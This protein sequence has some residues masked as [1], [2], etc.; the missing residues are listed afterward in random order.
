MQIRR[1]LAAL[2]TTALAWGGLVIADLPTAKAVCPAP[3]SGDPTVHAFVDLT[4]QGLGTSAPVGSLTGGHLS[5]PCATSCTDSWTNTASTAEDTETYTVSADSGWAVDHWSGCS[6]GGGTTSTCAVTPAYSVSSTQTADNTVD[7]AVYFRD[8]TPPTAQITSGPPTYTNQAATFTFTSDGTGTEATDTC[9]VDGGSYAPCSSPYAVGLLADGPHTLT[10]RATDGGDNTA[11]AS[12]SFT[13]DTQAPT[14]T[15]S[16][17]PAQG[18]YLNSTSASFTFSAADPNILQADCGDVASDAAHTTVTRDAC[19]SFTAPPNPT[20][21]GW[22]E[23][24]TNLPQGLHTWT[25]R[26][27][28]KAGNTA[29]QWRS[30]YVDSIAPTATFTGGPAEGATTSNTAPTFDFA[31]DGTGSTATA[32]CRLD[33]PVSIAPQPCTGSNSETLAG[34]TDGSYLLTLHLVDQAGNTADVARSFRVDTSVPTLSIDSGPA[35]G[36]YLGSTNATFGF[37]AGSGATAIT[38]QVDQDAARP[39][40]SNSTDLLTNLSDGSHSWTVQA[41]N[42]AGTS[43]TQTRTFTV[44]TVSPTAAITSGVADLGFTV[45]PTPTFDFVLDGTGSVPT[46]KCSVDSAQATT[47]TTATSYVTPA[48]GAGRH[49]VHVAVTDAAGNTTT[50]SRAFT[51]DLTRP[52]VGPRRHGRC[53]Q[54]Q[55]LSRSRGTPSIRAA[56]SRRAT[57]KCNTPV[58]QVGSAPGRRRPAGSGRRRR[59]FSVP[60]PRRHLLR[61]CPRPRH[62]R[63][64]EQLVGTPLHSASDRRC[65][66]RPIVTLEEDRW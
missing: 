59:A 46:A 63:Q 6:S 1:L 40:A 28:D 29:Q 66:A 24:L 2:I 57:C 16:S 11:Q 58:R 30:W 54:P 36:S 25:V 41:T 19:G 3:C 47:C 17:G 15:I 34:L 51:I 55:P 39:C 14:T 56:A 12:R 22:Q 26:A 32:T 5:T 35:A 64:H 61:P 8:T 49:T 23:T 62:R 21:V 52:T 31:L 43:T 48:L 10:V 4:V 7:V 38:C 9:A 42:A 20:P 60:E 18:S 44:D 33:G 53:S 65:V 50:I 37:T 13:V 45:D 27:V